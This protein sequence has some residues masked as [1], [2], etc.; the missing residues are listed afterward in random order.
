MVAIRGI[1]SFVKAVEAGSIAGGARLLGV[2]PAAASQNISRLEM[3]LGVRLLTRTT[4]RLALTE[5]GATY[6]A[7]VRELVQELELAGQAVNA[8]HDSPRGRLRIAST[9]AF[10]RH[11]LAPMIPEFNRRYPDITVE[12]SIADRNVDHIAESVDASIRIRH[13]LEDGLVAR[14][15][16]RVPSIFCAAPRY[17]ERAG[18]PHALEQ[19]K[20]H[21]CLV[22]RFPMDGRYLGWGAIRNGIRFEAPVNPRM[23]SDD[24]DALAQMAIAGGGVTRLAAFIAE[25]LIEQGK[26][27]ALFTPPLAGDEQ[28]EIDPLEFYLCVRHRRELTPKVRA[29]HQF[30]IDTLPARWRA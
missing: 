24:I 27:V 29:F 1:E 11:I 25:P 23:I 6:Y 8:L 7:K 28:L 16:A 13:A 9:G 19:L 17:L 22:F 3:H 18:Y 10:A 2:S 12:L 30:L 4:R 21:D 15:V 20:E 14:P 5:S 26:L